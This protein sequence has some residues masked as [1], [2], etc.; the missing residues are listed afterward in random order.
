MKYITVPDPITLSNGGEII[1]GMKETTLYLFL[2]QHALNDKAFGEGFKAISAGGRIQTAVK[3]SKP[4]D[5]IPLEESDY[6]MLKAAIDRP[7]Q[8]AGQ[9]MSP[10]AARQFLPFMEA[11]MDPSDKAVKAVKSK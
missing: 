2:N 6:D 8:V 10:E 3:D 1:P 11:V 7:N 9:P 4:G 5:V